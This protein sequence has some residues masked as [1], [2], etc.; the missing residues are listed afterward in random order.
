MGFCRAACQMGPALSLPIHY[1]LADSSIFGKMKVQISHIF[2]SHLRGFQVKPENA[3]HF[4]SLAS[5]KPCYCVFLSI[6]VD[7][8]YF[9]HI[10]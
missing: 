7:L 1:Q 3:L 4:L 8:P 2:L 10:L 6:N 9:Y 5:I